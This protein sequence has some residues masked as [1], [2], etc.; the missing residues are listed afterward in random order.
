MHK[1][2]WPKSL[3]HH[4]NYALVGVR[5]R[6]S[7][8][9]LTRFCSR[10]WFDS[11]QESWQNRVATLTTPSQTTILGSIRSP[12]TN[13]PLTKQYVLAVCFSLYHMF[14]RQKSVSFKCFTTN[15]RSF[16]LEL[17]IRRVEDIYCGSNPLTT[18]AISLHGMLK[19]Q[20]NCITSQKQLTLTCKLV[21][22]EGRRS[23]TSKKDSHD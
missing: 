21:R 5:V 8:A 13:A 11:G 19:S 20:P 14:L 7:V 12:G 22:W 6:D 17:S 9:I 18:T 15:L 1:F 3:I 16:D 2:E 4:P 23:S 10:F